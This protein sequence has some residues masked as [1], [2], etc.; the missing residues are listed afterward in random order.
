MSGGFDPPSPETV[1]N[2]KL[3]TKFQVHL[4]VPELFLLRFFVN[5]DVSEIFS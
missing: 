4:N 1:R 5:D 3:I 2:L